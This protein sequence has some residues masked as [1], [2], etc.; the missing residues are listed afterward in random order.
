MALR[1]SLFFCLIAGFASLAPAFTPGAG[2]GQQAPLEKV[3]VLALDG[4][5]PSPAPAPGQA[6]LALPASSARAFLP[7]PGFFEAREV[8][9]YQS[10]ATREFFARKQVNYRANIQVWAVFL[11]KYQIPFH[12][13]NAV[14]RLENAPPGVLLLP[15]SVALSE[16]EKRAVVAFRNRGGSVLATWQCATHSE[17]GRKLG[18]DFMAQALDTEVIGDTQ[19]SAQDEFLIPHG[20]SPLVQYLPAGTRVWLERTKDWY[21]LR[22]SAR[23][24]AAHIM[25]WSRTPVY[26]KPSAAIVFDERE[27]P[28]G[29][30]SRSA[31]LGYPEQLWASSD[32][33]QIES[34]AHN[35]LMWLLRQPAAY[36]AAWP[37]PFKSAFVMAVDVTDTLSAADLLNARLLEEAGGR[38]T[39]YLVGATAA[40]SA[41]ALRQ[42]QLAG[43]ELAYLGDTYTEFRGHPAAVQAQRFEA[44]RGATA[45]AGL[46]LAPGAGFKAPL[47]SYDRT[48][49][50]LLGK[51]GFGHLLAGVDASE[52]RLPFFL[53]DG[54]AAGARSGQPLVVLPRTQNGPEDSV[55]NCTPGVGIKPFLNELET[56]FA[57][58]GLSIAA[59]SGESELSDAQ[60]AELFT[61]LGSRRERV[62]LATA[63]QVAQWWHERARV[64]AR[65]QPGPDGFS[66]RVTVR[67]G[68][69]L[70]QAPAVWVNLPWP[71]ALLRLVAQGRHAGRPA[72]AQVDAWRSA[73]LLGELPPGEYA[74]TLHFD[75][76]V[77]AVR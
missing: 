9:L 14:E 34:I 75:P 45:V 57:M 74:W 48:T 3:Q 29:M 21:P 66:L 12:I 2:S 23:Q 46:A 47:D 58:G 67:P 38:A 65:F 72:I 54:D 16:R 13:V 43:H 7:A 70:R 24:S 53:P 60:A 20:D 6:A 55:D 71:G 5:M 30:M 11:S 61:Y 15:S 32:P 26:A 51:R 31:V 22:L 17:S 63:S 44:M 19:A 25:N 69:A 68:A 8:T 33:Q 73:V 35:V 4:R 41:T 50:A 49:E 28:S 56:A 40:E 37:H 18:F 52:A 36:V 62:W 10:A 42:L 77:A 39:Y 59:L 76:A 1:F 64:E 27:Q